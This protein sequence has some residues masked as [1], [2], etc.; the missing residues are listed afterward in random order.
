MNTF[1]LPAVA[2]AILGFAAAAQALPAD[3]HAPVRHIVHHAALR[4]VVEV[5]RVVHVIH[6][7]RVVQV[8]VEAP[9]PAPVIEP[10]FP[11][12]IAAPV[13]VYRGWHDHA[14]PHEGWY[15]GPREQHAGW[16]PGWQHPGWHHEYGWHRRFG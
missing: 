14:W 4:H 6:E 7:V 10:V 16:Q 2:T 11:M 9:R 1:L 5:T 3:C 15:R 8:P 13:P 12:P